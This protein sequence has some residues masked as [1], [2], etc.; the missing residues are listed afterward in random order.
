MKIA[1]DD[2]V[3]LGLAKL[4]SLLLIKAMEASRSTKRRFYCFPASE[5]VEGPFELVE[6]AGL[7]RSK[8]IAA[9]TPTLVE[10]EEQWI[11]FQDRPE[12]HFAMEM[13]QEAI[14]QH[15]QEQVEAQTSSFSPRKLLT[16]LWIMAPVLLYVLYR[17]LRMYIA[18]HLSHDLSAPP[19][20]TPGP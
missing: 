7:L 20:S 13:P 5:Q 16:F 11:P 19:D 12:Y 17:F 3:L 2:H 10:G 8:H 15:V 14:T 18:Y 4:R 1:N 6:L 9:E